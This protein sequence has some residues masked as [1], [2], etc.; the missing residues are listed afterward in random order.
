MV[1][2]SR[3]SIGDVK[4]RLNQVITHD[5][6]PRLGV[7]SQQEMTQKYSKLSD[8]IARP[9]TTKQTLTPEETNSDLMSVSQPFYFFEDRLKSKLQ[10]LENSVY[11]SALG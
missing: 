1:K 8:W 9:I 3:N 10:S 7:E 6:Y 2:A 11:H 4:E 5:L